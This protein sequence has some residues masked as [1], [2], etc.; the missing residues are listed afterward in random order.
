MEWKSLVEKATKKSVITLRTDNGGEYT[1]TQFKEYLKA[2][3]IWHELTIPKTPQQNG[4]AECLNRTLVEMALLDA[5][6]PKKF[7]AEAV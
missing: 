1:S 2:K 3:C 4:V 6:L 7:W 5:K